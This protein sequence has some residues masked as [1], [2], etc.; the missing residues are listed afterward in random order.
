M[1][2]IKHL[3]FYWILLLML[4]SCTDD[5]KESNL[6]YPKTGFQKIELSETIRDEITVTSTQTYIYGKNGRLTAFS[7]LQTP[8]GK[9]WEIRNTTLVEYAGYQAT[10]ADDAGNVSAYILDDEGYAV[11][12]TRTE[13][14]G[15][16][17]YY[18]F[19][20]FVTATGKHYLK[21]ITETLEKGAA[22]CARIN[23]D[24]TDT[25]QFVVTQW[26]RDD[27][28][29]FKM[30]FP[31]IN[32]TANVSEIPCVGLAETY[33]LSLH[34]AALYGKLLG[35]TYDVL[36]SKIEPV[37]SGEGQEGDT[38]TYSYTTDSRGVVTSCSIVT[39]CCGCNYY[40]TIDYVIE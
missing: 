13:G 6:V 28:W 12:C 32:G 40:R 2:H 9:E 1:I 27:S 18:T 25:N 8:D 14:G 24:Y 15:R 19:S 5:E 20:Y 37:V 16:F 34:S 23:I 36:V 29:S 11:E 7:G 4:L 38:D 39:N 35:D 30:S 26:V 31:D 33:P 10:I 21:E 22:P 3:L 17:R